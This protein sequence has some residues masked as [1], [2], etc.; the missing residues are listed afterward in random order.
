M[1]KFDKILIGIFIA[2]VVIWGLT[3]AATFTAMQPAPKEPC[4]V[5]LVNVTANVTA[6]PAPKTPHP[7]VTI[8]F[9]MEDNCPFCAQQAPIMNALAPTHNITTINLTSNPNGAALAKQWN[10]STTPTTII[11]HNGKEY[12]RFTSVTDQTTLA[13]AM[14]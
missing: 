14:A 4:P 12:Q 7:V 3:V 6:T 11:L 1:N 8:L 9:F 10:I 2:A 13:A 5:V